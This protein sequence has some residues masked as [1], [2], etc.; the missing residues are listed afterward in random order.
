MTRRRQNN[1]KT[2]GNY[3]HSNAEP[4]IIEKPLTFRAA[5]L[6]LWET[7]KFRV[8]PSKYLGHKCYIKN[9][10]YTISGETLNNFFIA[11]FPYRAFPK[12]GNKYKI[13]K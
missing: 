9:R 5:C 2:F 4:A 8:L 10:G 6:I 3:S 12:V 13:S 1:R 11:A 7:I